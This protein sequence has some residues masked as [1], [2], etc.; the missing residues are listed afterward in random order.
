MTTQ[1]LTGGE[2][3]VKSL[4]ALGV[5]TIFALPG[6]QN[7]YL[8]N[9]LHDHRDQIRVV[10]TRHEQGAAY[11]AMGYALSLDKPGVFCVCARHAGQLL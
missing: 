6:V 7:D 2:A 3:I 10:H 9:A 8:F 11:M 4:I 1:L 5:D